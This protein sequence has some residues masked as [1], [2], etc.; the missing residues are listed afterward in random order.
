MILIKKKIDDIFGNRKKPAPDS[1]LD[2]YKNEKISSYVHKIKD[3]FIDKS[4]DVLVENICGRL[5]RYFWFLPASEGHHHA[6]EF[7]LFTHCLDTS[8]KAIRKFDEA[9][10]FEYRDNNDIDSF[11][12][13]KKR[14][15]K[16]YAFFVCGLLHD[17]GKV[18]RY[19]VVAKDGSE[20]NPCNNLYDFAISHRLSFEDIRYKSD[21][22]DLYAHIEKITP[23]FAARIIT[24]H[25]Y[26]YIGSGYISDILKEVGFK[27]DYAHNFSGIIKE[28][29]MESTRDNLE[30]AQPQNDIV[31]H[32]IE[33]L[34]RMFEAGRVAINTPGA[35]A[36]VFENYTAIHIGIL[37]EIRTLLLSKDSKTPEVNAILKKM[38][39]RKY[40]DFVDWKCVYGMEIVTAGKPF[41]VKVV[42]IKNT[43][44]WDRSPKM[45]ICKLN[46]VFNI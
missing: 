42:K 19:N 23:F 32:F 1:F 46:V 44:I 27:K 13:R 39:D 12:T 26:S 17:I 6:Q 38:V 40:V 45:D 16:Q 24:A 43:L 35:K 2:A 25:D 3:I 31:S 20:W 29:D 11:E 9:V 37:N 5:L 41:I 34:K 7:G 28:A 14:T 33:E 30:T 10:F 15:H 4:A 21:D 22:K 36:W 8:I 18:I